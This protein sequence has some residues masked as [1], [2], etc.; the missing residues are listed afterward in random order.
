MMPNYFDGLSIRQIK[1]RL[2]LY[3]AL[4]LY[5]RNHPGIKT[6]RVLLRLTKRYEPPQA[7]RRGRFENV[8][9]EAIYSRLMRQR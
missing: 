3:G 1:A 4:W 7:I 6:G 9:Q 8:Q 5:C 2:D